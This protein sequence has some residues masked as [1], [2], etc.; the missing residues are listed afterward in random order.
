[1]GHF[2]GVRYTLERWGILPPGSARK[3]VATTGLRVGKFIAPA[4]E[5]V[6]AT[7]EYLKH[8]H[9]DLVVLA[10]HQREGLSRWTHRAVAEPIARR[11]KTMTLFVPHGVDGFISLADSSVSLEHVLI[12]VDAAP[13]PQAAVDVAVQLAQTL[14]VNDV[15]FTLVYVGAEGD[16]PAVQQTDQPGWT[17]ERAVRQGAVVEQILDAANTCSA[18][19]IVLATEGRQGFLDALRGSTTERIVRGAACPVLAIPA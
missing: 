13:H 9:A 4:K 2:P 10:T 17:W 1:M 12:P 3:D 7:I 15:T 8:K 11:A 6:E 16:M 14:E 19:L 18:D 5:P